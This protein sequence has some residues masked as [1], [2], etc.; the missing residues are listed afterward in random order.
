MKE[1]KSFKTVLLIVLVLSGL[2]LTLTYTKSV[3]YVPSRS[4][5]P[6]L[7]VGDLIV[8]KRV[9]PEQLVQEYNS[10]KDKPIIVFDTPYSKDPWVHR[11]YQVVYD[12]NNQLV[13]FR[14]KGDNNPGPDSYL[15]KPE[16]IRGKVVLRIPLLGWLFMFA[17][18]ELG[19][20]IISI[21]IAILVVLNL[22]EFARVA[23]ERGRKK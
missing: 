7:M 9:T 13:G 17:K 8:L 1:D 2:W 22:V 16:D 15:V 18:S 10:L 6:T 21:I 19:F 20:T 12:E 5:E 3:Y 4:M 11:I 23:V 14:T